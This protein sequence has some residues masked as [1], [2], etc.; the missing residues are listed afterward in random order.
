[1]Y[2]QALRERDNTFTSRCQ[3]FLL[4]HLA[5]R[6]GDIVLKQI[7]ALVLLSIA[8]FVT[9][10]RA[11]AQNRAV[12]ATVPFDFIVGN[13]LLPS[14]SYTITSVS[15]GII[16]IQNYD[17]HVTTLSTFSQD[18]HESR[19]GKLVFDKYGDQYFL[20]EILCPDAA[21]NVSFPSSKQK[22]RART[23]GEVLHSSNQVVVALS[24]GI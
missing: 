11:L 10:G 21:V 6:Q 1:M 2:T 9:A 4:K 8:S 15:S 5:S 24:S 14:G 22:K 13:K 16:Q 7:T 20:A 12:Q 18:S 19:S 17:K 23:Q 3:A